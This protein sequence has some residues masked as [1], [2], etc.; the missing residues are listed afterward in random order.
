[1]STA[2]AR[3][4]PTALLTIVATWAAI[5]TGCCQHWCYQQPGCPPVA[6]QAG[7]VRYGAVCEAPGQPETVISQAQGSSP[8]I[9]NAPRPRVVVSEPGGRLAGNGGWRR[10]DPESIAT[11]RTEGALDESAT[12]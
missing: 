3:I 11:T 4:R 12:R 8:A 10:M 9:A 7:V 1:M 2:S 6:A 5:Q